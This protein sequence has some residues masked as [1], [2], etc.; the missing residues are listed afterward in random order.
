MIRRSLSVSLSGRWLKNARRQC[1]RLTLLTRVSV[2]A[3]EALARV[4]VDGLHTLPVEAGVI[5]TGSWWWRS[6]G[7]H[8]QTLNGHGIF[9]QTL[10]N[11]TKE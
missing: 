7:Q 1:R 10:I 5:L 4:V 9:Q 11:S 3:L 2:E 6:K 8:V